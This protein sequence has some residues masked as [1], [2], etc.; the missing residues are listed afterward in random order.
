MVFVLSLSFEKSLQFCEEIS[1]ARGFLRQKYFPLQRLQKDPAQF[2]CTP[3]GIVLPIVAAPRDTA[4]PRRVRVYQNVAA[5]RKN[6][7][8]ILKAI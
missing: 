2:H 6:H 8:S 1:R 3:Y 5:S 7:L 4:Q